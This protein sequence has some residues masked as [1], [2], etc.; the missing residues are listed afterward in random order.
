MQDARA[1]KT[2]VWKSLKGRCQ[3]KLNK[4]MSIDF[5]EVG[6]KD[7]GFIHLAQDRL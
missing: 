1:Y 3:H 5:K 4:G 2:L 7:M 6:C